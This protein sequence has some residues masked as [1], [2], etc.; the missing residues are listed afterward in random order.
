MNHDVAA[1]L[2]ASVELPLHAFER[3]WIADAQREV[4]TAVGVERLNRIDA[5]WHLPVSLAQLGTQLTAGTQHSVVAHEAQ[6]AVG[7]CSVEFETAFVL[8]ADQ[9]ETCGRIGDGC[10]LEVRFQSGTRRRA[11]L[12]HPLFDGLLR[13]R[14][15]RVSR[16]QDQRKA[17][18]NQQARFHDCWKCSRFRI[19]RK[20]SKPGSESSSSVARRR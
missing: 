3:I 5:L 1:K 7:T 6:L 18:E 14:G 12:F 20:H 15:G 17:S 2:G 10:F 11:I 9:H 8:D 4:K 16:Q 13:E 19:S